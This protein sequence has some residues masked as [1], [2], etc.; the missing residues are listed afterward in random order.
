MILLNPVLLNLW[1]TVP[2]E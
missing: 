1:A 2:F